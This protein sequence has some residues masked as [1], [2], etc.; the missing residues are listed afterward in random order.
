[1]KKNIKKI[2][3]IASIIAVFGATVVH[4]QSVVPV[5][6][7]R[8]P[9]A[10]VIY[11]PFLG[12]KVG[13]GTTS[14]YAPLSV[15]G[16]IVGKNFTATSTVATSSIASGGFSVHTNKF[17]VQ[18]N[19]GNVGLGTSSPAFPF[20]SAA[21]KNVFTG[22]VSVTDD[23]ADDSEQ[24]RL[25][26]QKTF[27]DLSGNRRSF[28]SQATFSNATFDPDPD[29]G[30]NALIVAGSFQCNTD[31]AN[32]TNM[33]GTI[34]NGGMSCLR[35]RYT[36]SGSGFI[37]YAR[38]IQGIIVQNG[39]G[40]QLIRKA[41]SFEAS[42]PRQT[43]ASGVI[44]EWNGYLIRP[45]SSTGDSNSGY[46]GSARGFSVEALPTT[47]TSSIAFYAASD[48]FSYG[49]TTPTAKLNVHTSD[50]AQTSPAFIIASSTSATGATTT[51]FMVRNGNVAIGTTSTSA[52]LTMQTAASGANTALLVANGQTNLL[53]MTENGRVTLGS[54]TD[55]ANGNELL[56]VSGRGT[57]TGVVINQQT[58][59]SGT[60]GDLR[61]RRRNETA[62][63][64]SATVSGNRL[65][66]I[67]FDG[68]TGSA[69]VTAVQFRVT[70][71][72]NITGSNIGG[73]FFI[74]IASTSGS[75]PGQAL[76]IDGDRH[77][78]LGGT[79]SVLPAILNIS[80]D[81]EASA[82]NLAIGTGENDHKDYLIVDSQDNGGRVGV[83]TT[84]PWRTLSV[85]GTMSVSGLTLNTGSSAASICLSSG[86]EVTRNTDNETCL[87]SSIRYK[88][89]VRAVRGGLAKI[90][91]LKPVTFDYKDGSGKDRIGLIAEDV[92]RVDEH[93]VSVDDGGIPN[94][95]R[96]SHVTT[97][98][99]QGVQDI[100]A[101]LTGL[102]EKLNEQQRTIEALDARLRALEK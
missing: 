97:M 47:A 67:T 51:Q 7:Q 84:S 13:I 81:Y 43:N 98:L 10:G 75:T 74:E 72:D 16:E 96:W 77:V 87:A 32:A 101:R 28:L 5:G 14:P 73:N 102:E 62:G 56:Y 53:S 39:S 89:N 46:I 50:L 60:A 36:N 41:A 79:I 20:S 94:G 64:A 92:A 33:V 21:T 59:A 19:T 29:V 48:P 15:A 57:R 25:L 58:S 30:S 22:F 6:L 61:I 65:G 88:K 1:M 52:G 82:P 45:Y 83:A 63:V 3:C 34:T 35:A 24:S 85:G 31:S 86:N 55:A 40:A 37:D 78:G 99:I 69:D 90:L 42:P 2:A 4:A 27:S 80:S 70:Q 9:S 68:Y 18:Q 100:V 11:F 44:G 66:L 38:P 93:L 91:D 12:D 23:G 17:L 76:K 54:T 49:S 95:I 71:Q 8:N 26:V